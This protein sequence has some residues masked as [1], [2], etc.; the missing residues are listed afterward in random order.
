MRIPLE[1][2]DFNISTD[3]NVQTHQTLAGA[4]VTTPQAQTQII[5][6]KV[7]YE[8][9]SPLSHMDTSQYREFLIKTRDSILYINGAITRWDLIHTVDSFPTMILE[10]ACD[11]LWQEPLNPEVDHAQAIEEIYRNTPPPDTKDYGF[12]KPNSPFN[13]DLL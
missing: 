8:P 6:V 3:F 1:V 2:I 7:Y 10:I 5:T 9:G 13:E 4:N 11:D 12:L